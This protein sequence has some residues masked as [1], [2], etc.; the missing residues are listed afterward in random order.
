MLDHIV[1]QIRDDPTTFKTCC[2]ASKSW[3]RWTRKLLFARISFNT[4]T[5]VE[6]WKNAF[7][8]PT[9]SPA[10]HARSLSIRQSLLVTAA[11]VDTIT[12]FCCVES[13]NVITNGWDE[14]IS[15][16]PLHGLSPVLRSLSLTFISPQTRRCLASFGPF[17][18]LRI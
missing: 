11:N 3:I 17:P 7:P 8:D 15:L 9:N 13:L 2:L 1:D 18:F 16:T 6:S 10:H 14:R 4:S 5:C 12:T